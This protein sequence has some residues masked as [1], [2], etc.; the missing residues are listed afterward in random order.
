MRIGIEVGDAMGPATIET[1]IG[2]IQE[3]ADAGLETA[4]MAQL[5]GWDA[6]TALA[7]AG[8]E[9]PGIA[10]GTAIVQTYPRHPLALASQALSVQAA[11]GNRLELGIGPSHQFIIEGMF[12]YSFEKPAR[13]VRDY[14][15]VLGPLLRSETASYQGET[16]KVE[17]TVAIPGAEP[18]SL[19]L[20]AAG[21]RMLQLAGEFTDGTITAWTGPST[22]ADYIVPTIS[23]AATAAGR[24]APRVI[25]GVLVH[26]TP[27]AAA[28]RARLAG[29]FATAAATPSYRAMLDREGVANPIDLLAAG[30]EAAVERELRRYLDA[31]ATEIL[32][33]PVGP[34]EERARTLALLADLAHSSAAIG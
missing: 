10:L 17:G 28:A 30:D 19:L 1:I 18:P 7:V 3:A 23:R 15:A 11:T 32:A 31:G 20:A 6:L 26:V 34:D 9:V 12:G 21:P 14:L 4:W 13:H 27:D 29:S 24:P 22:I 8:R 2:R 16:L 25:A 5:F 33:F